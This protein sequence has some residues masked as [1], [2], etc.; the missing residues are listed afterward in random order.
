MEV[1]FRLEVQSRT[2]GCA[3]LVQVVGQRALG[4]YRLGFLFRVRVDPQSRPEQ[5]KVESLFV[6]IQAGQTHLADIT[7]NG[8]WYGLNGK[9]DAIEE[10]Q[11]TIWASLD[12]QQMS[13]L[14]LMRN[15][16][17]LSFQIGLTSRVS[18]GAGPTF[19]RTDWQTLTLNQSEWLDILRVCGYSDIVTLELA[20][21]KANAHPHLSTA[22][23]HLQNAERLLRLGEWT[24]CAVHCRKAMVALRAAYDEHDMSRENPAE[25]FDNQKKKSMT[26]RFAVARRAALLLTQPGAHLEL[27]PAAELFTS[28]DARTIFGLTH[29]L[30]NHATISLAT[31]K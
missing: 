15:G 5:A 30:V 7:P 19:P 4:R 14:E 17:V 18:C 3:D 1:R 27:E 22:V 21:V 25:W 23:G 26:E 12:G 10:R 8:D 28:S 6:T 2:V 20:K 9:P 31:T 24:D 11:V 29:L 13:A 16:S